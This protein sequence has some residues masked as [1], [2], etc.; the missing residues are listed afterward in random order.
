MALG[1]DPRKL[2]RVLSALSVELVGR[3]KERHTRVETAKRSLTFT[4]LVR[5]SILVNRKGIMGRWGVPNAET[6]VLR[7]VICN[8]GELNLL[9]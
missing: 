1:K 5:L 9:D 8:P 6:W 7:L 3:A 2:G 4:I